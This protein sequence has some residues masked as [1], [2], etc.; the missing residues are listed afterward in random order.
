MI[1]LIIITILSILFAIYCFRN[2]RKYDIEIEKQN[3]S[4]RKE[5]QILTQQFEKLEDELD[6]LTRKEKEVGYQ[7]EDKLSYLT[8][9]EDG[10]KK[11][12]DNQKELCQEAFNNWWN[13]L[14]KNYQEKEAEYNL[15]TSNLEKS[16]ADAQQKILQDLQLVRA[17]LDKI[18]ATRAAAIEAQR[19]EKEISE[20]LS[21][22]CLSVTP[23]ELDDIKRLE[24]VKQDLHNPRILS[25]LIWQTYWQKP[26]TKLCNDVLGASAVTGIYKIT[27]QLTGECY[28]G[29]SVNV[30]DRWK[31]HAKCGCA[32][33]T[34]AGNKL[35]KAMIEDGIWN[36][37]WELLEQCSREELDEKEKFYINLYKSYDFGY[38]STKGNN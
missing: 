1:Y 23:N 14:E 38:N 19:K 26:M 9:I 33:D 29:Q 25:M 7:I 37:S 6:D 12:Q 5:N 32:I 22:Y 24:R 28:I 27:N 34:P 35:Y 36:F 2:K 18:E 4:L 13:L 31:Q 30:P 21:F 20:Q 16:Y 10:I 8:S 11:T 15:L 3:K 17:E